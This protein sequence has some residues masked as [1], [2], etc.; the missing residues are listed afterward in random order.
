MKKIMYASV[1]SAMLAMP[2]SSE[3]IGSVDTTWRI[4]NNDSIVV[5]VFDDPDIKNVS[6][7]VSYA[8]TGGVSGAIGLAEDPSRFSIACRAIGELPV[9][10]SIP[11][12]QTNVF[13]RDTNFF[14]KSMDVT[15]MYDKK[16]NVIIYEVSSS[17]LIDGSPF[18][19]ISVVPVI[20]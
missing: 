7:Y 14:F 4:F 20:Q 9:I 2:A 1:L 16:R 6:C 18:N 10:D 17:K 8:K 19:S 12:K 5:E 15:R 3:V 11:K 13:S